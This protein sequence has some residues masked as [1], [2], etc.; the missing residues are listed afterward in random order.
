MRIARKKLCR[1]VMSENSVFGLVGE[2]ELLR[3]M[4][5]NVSTERSS[6]GQ[7]ID[8]EGILGLLAGL[9]HDCRIA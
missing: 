6:D 5:M 2:G 1:P 7:M 9:V 4:I 8:H 3:R